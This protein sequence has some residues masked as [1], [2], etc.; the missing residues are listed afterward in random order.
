MRSLFS[1]GL[2]SVRNLHGEQNFLSRIQGHSQTT[3]GFREGNVNLLLR[4]RINK[5]IAT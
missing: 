3:S 5:G 4:H 1:S 2:T